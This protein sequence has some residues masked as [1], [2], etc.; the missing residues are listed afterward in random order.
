MTK[1]LR[2]LVLAMLLTGS[3]L[4]SFSAKVTV[5]EARSIA[6]DFV[7]SMTGKSPESIRLKAVNTS[8]TPATPLY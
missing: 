4:N 2:R 1:H 6:T 3:T 7:S 8:T 5:E